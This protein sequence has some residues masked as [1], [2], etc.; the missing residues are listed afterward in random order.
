MPTNKSTGRVLVPL[1]GSELA[2]AILPL[3]EGPQHP[4]GAEVLLIRSVTTD[5][6]SNPS[7]ETEAGDYL[8]TQARRLERA[9]LR[10]RCEVW[11]GDPSQAIVNAA[12]RGR[13]GLIAMTTHG[14]RG[15]DRL[16]FG[17]VAESVVRK[18]RVPVL[19]VREQVRWPTDRPPRILVPLDGS[20]L[21]AAILTVIA[22]FR[23]PLQGVVEL[24]HVLEVPPRAPHLDL[25]LS[26]TDARPERGAARD[27]LERVAARLAA[28]GLEVEWVVVDGP[29]GPMIAQRVADGGTDLVAMTTHGRSGVARLFLGSVA[30]QVLR[31]ADVPVLLW[32]VTVPPVVTRRER[33]TEE[34]RHAN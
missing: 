20:A 24:L 30:E 7:A 3:L 22:R 23:Q 29:V 17:S 16:R 13:V 33:R 31:T 2:E 10:V 12:V 5:A 18:A 11:H 26:L 27:Y 8:A 15:L 6:P 21:S 32:K 25:P 14:W 1:D 19:L 4:W 9:G 28:K 34:V